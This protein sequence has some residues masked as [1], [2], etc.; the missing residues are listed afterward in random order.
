MYIYI[1]KTNTT[2][3]FKCSFIKQNEKYLI[4]IHIKINK[5]F[6]TENCRDSLHNAN[7]VKPIEKNSAGTS[8]LRTLYFK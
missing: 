4:T 2:F 5:S 3:Y 7:T 6:K 8:L 1:I